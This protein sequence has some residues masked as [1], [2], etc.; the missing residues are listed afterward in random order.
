MIWKGK[1]IPKNP[2]LRPNRL[3]VN[4]PP[5]AVAHSARNQLRGASAEP[6]R[7]LLFPSAPSAWRMSTSASV[8]SKATTAGE[9]LQL[10]AAPVCLGN[11]SVDWEPGAL[12]TADWFFFGGR[13]FKWKRQSWRAPFS[14]RDGLRVPTPATPRGRRHARA[15]AGRGSANW[16]GRGGPTSNGPDRV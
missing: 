5:S 10:I 13:V 9:K 2:Q 1:N 7:N 6:T 3:P 4:L 11:F 12:V 8:A 16:T 15:H 14:W